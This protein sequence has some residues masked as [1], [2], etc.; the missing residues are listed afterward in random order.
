M[1]VF[2]TGTDTNVGKT[3]IANWI[4]LQT[5]FDY[6]KPIQC[7]NLTDSD[8][9]SITALSHATV[10]PES[11]VLEQ[12]LSPHAAAALESKSI[13]LAQITLPNSDRLIIEGAGGTLVPINQH[14]FMI[15]LIKQFNTPVIVV[16]RSTLGTINHTCL[17]LEALRL[18][19]IP[20]LGV[21]MN[22]PLNPLNKQAIEFYGKTN[23]LAEFP[24]LDE[25]AVEVLRNIPLSADLQKI[26]L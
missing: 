9:L 11:Y 4:C 18:R 17:T 13:D 8:T 6:W 24:M 15:D 22:G 5:G 19:N 23:V 25:V 14:F 16:S 12:P 26:L 7:G 3:L 21:I 2:L 20:V 10:F 1:K